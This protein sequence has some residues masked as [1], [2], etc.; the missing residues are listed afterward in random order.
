[1]PGRRAPPTLAW[2]QSPP[3]LSA[4]SPRDASG[5]EPPGAGPKG[6]L[7]RL[8]FR[9]VGSLRP[10]P[11]KRPETWNGG[12]KEFF[13]SKGC[14]PWIA[15]HKI[16]KMSK[17]STYEPSCELSKRRTCVPSTSGVSKIAALCL[18]LLRIL[19]LY[20]LHLLA[21]LQSVTLL[22]CSLDAS[23][24]MPAVVLYCCTFQDWLLLSISQSCCLAT[25]GSSS[26]QLRGRRGWTLPPRS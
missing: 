18:L 19:Q 1:M 22:A 23:P 17:S 8:A 2:N 6:R 25:W 7:W 15:V 4:R 21:L 3:A 24:W 14:S 12:E 26:C 11:V 13:S 9:A 16:R 10:A 5:R 20:H